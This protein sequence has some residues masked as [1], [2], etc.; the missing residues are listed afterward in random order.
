MEGYPRIFANYFRVA[1]EFESE[2][3]DALGAWAFGVIHVEG[4]P[5]TKPPTS[6]SSTIDCNCLMSLVNFVRLIVVRGVAMVWS[7][8]DKAMPM[9]FLPTSRPRSALPFGR[10]FMMFSSLSIMAVDGIQFP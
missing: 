4:S 1:D 3:A 10:A 8:L 6:Y 5:M 7:G 2:I 9:V